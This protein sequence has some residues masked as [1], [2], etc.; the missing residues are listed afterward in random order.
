[1][2]RGIARREYGAGRG[3]VAT[4]EPEC[5]PG[6]RLARWRRLRALPGA[7]IERTFGLRGH[8]GAS[9]ERTFGLTGRPNARD[10][11]TAKPRSLRA[12]AGLGRREGWSRWGLMVEH[13]ALQNTSGWGGRGS[14]HVKNWLARTLVF[15]HRDPLGG[16]PWGGA[17]MTTQPKVQAGDGLAGRLTPRHWH[18]IRAHF[19]RV[20]PTEFERRTGQRA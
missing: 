10:P 3:S 9:T 6:G 14:P 7:L 5:R 16:A 19:E 1:M 20:I 4:S 2:P 12:E 18:S 17:P 8:L 11:G 13:V 15:R